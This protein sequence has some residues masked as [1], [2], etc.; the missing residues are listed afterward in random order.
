[1]DGCKEYVNPNLGAT[2]RI[3]TTKSDI[4]LSL[5]RA[6]HRR[7]G[8]IKCGGLFERSEFRRAPAGSPTHRVKRDTGVFF[9]FVFFHAQENEQ[10]CH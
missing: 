9:W 4:D 6:E 5:S 10:I 3:L 2:E 7:Y 1:M 8:R